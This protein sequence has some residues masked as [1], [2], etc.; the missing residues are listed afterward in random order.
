[1]WCDELLP[2]ESWT[3]LWHGLIICGHCSGIRHIEKNCSGCGDPGPCK[4]EWTELRKQDGS[5]FQIPSVF[6]G[7]EG[8]F[9]DYVYLKMLEREWKRP[10]LDSEDLEDSSIAMLASPRAAIVLLFWSYFE[11]RI[12]RLLRRGMQKV[13][14][15]LVE[16]TLG[17]YSFIGARIDRLYKI[18]FGTTYM[19]DLIDL[20]YP[21]VAAHLSEIQRRRN[22]FTHGN[23]G[24][25]D[26]AL[27]RT[28]VEKLKAEH[29][30][31]IAVFNKRTASPQKSD[32]TIKD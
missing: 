21:E 6:M 19:A 11:T 18:L 29:E 22:D 3:R 27:V 15:N 13:P 24:A 26:D 31:W 12:E 5:T 8:R 32:V 23:P 20:G 1:M 25:I 7:A 16:D 9:E 30:A 28:V 10:L 4:T 2:N 14:I 17:R